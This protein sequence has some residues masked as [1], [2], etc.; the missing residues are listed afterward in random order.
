MGRLNTVWGRS[1]REKW[2]KIIKPAASDILANGELIYRPFN[3]AQM[4]DLNASLK[5][6]KERETNS[7]AKKYSRK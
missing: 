3:A 5:N 6:T 7:T 2:Y 1:A 4:A